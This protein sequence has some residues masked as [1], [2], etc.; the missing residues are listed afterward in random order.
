VAAWLRVPEG[1][2][3]RAWLFSEGI[4]LRGPMGRA[5]GLPWLVA[6]LGML[7]AGL[8]LVF[9][10]A[11]WSALAVAAAV[12][13]QV[14]ILPWWRAVPVGA[15]LGALFDLFVLVVLLSPWGDQLIQAMG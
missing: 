4:T 6:A 9:G 10:Q 2:A 15:R 3:D 1:F 12:S 11:W 13:S 5:F 14:A 8:G 7:G